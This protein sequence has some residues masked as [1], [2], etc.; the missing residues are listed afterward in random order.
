MKGSD[1][2]RTLLYVNIF[3][4][5]IF[6]AAV[7][8]VLLALGAV[9]LTKRFGWNRIVIAAAVLA[10]IVIGPYSMVHTVRKTLKAFEDPRDREDFRG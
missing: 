7:P 8:P 6:C 4:N 1:I 9:Y 3:L 2:Y 5:G 10:G